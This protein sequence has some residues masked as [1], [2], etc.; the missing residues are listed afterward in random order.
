[1]ALIV[2]FL[3]AAIPFA[4]KI[5]YRQRVK[6]GLTIHDDEKQD[7]PRDYLDT[8]LGGSRSATLQLSQSTLHLH[9]R[10]YATLKLKE[11]E[12]K[13]LIQTKLPKLG[14]VTIITVAYFMVEAYGC[15]QSEGAPKEGATYC[16][17]FTG[18]LLSEMCGNK[19]GRGEKTFASTTT[20]EGVELTCEVDGGFGKCEDIIRSSY[21]FA[22]LFVIFAVLRLYVGPL[23]ELRYTEKHI[24]RFDML[25]RDQVR[26]C[27]VKEGSDEK[28]CFG[29]TYGQ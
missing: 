9:A 27:H 4:G 29:Y 28:A 18:D 15:L 8:E 6:M 5:L 13:E 19:T 14:L 21:V 17:Q 16:Y 2:F 22:F 23:A 1:M 26:L 24:L 12:F 20:S 25:F 3:F 11:S 10:H 7:L